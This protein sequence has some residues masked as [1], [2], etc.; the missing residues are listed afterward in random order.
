MTELRGVF[1]AR[2]RAVAEDRIR[3]VREALGSGDVDEARREM[4][5]L[6]GEARVVGFDVVARIAHHLEE[7]LEGEVAGELLERGLVL[8]EDALRLDPDAEP[9]GLDS[10]LA[11]GR[12][13]DATATSAAAAEPLATIRDRASD[14][15]VRADLGVLAGLVRSTAELRATERE[16]GT[17]IEELRGLEDDE[18]SRE[19]LLA[20]IRRALGGARQLAFDHRRRCDA[21]ID[22]IRELRMVPLH[23]LFE[24]FPRAIAQLAA[25]L[26][27]EV[28]VEVV[29]ADVEIDRQV[30]EVVT[31]PLLHLVRNA[32]DHGLETPDERR[33]GGKSPRGKIALR[34]RASGGVAR[35]EVEDDGRGVDV[36]AV[37][38]AAGVSE[39][40][41]EGLLDALCRHGLSTRRQVTDVS[42]RGVGLDV[43][44]RR[45]ASVG[46]RLGLR[47]TPGEGTRFVLELPTSMVLSAMVCVEVDGARYALAPH[48][49]GQVL[50]GEA[51]EPGPA[52]RGRAVRI[53]ERTLPLVDLGV[54][55]G[56]VSSPRDRER[57]LVLHQGER[58][59]AAGIDRFMGTRPVSEQ[60]L[61]PFLEQLPIVR[62]V[63]VLANGQLAVVLDVAD[64]IR[65]AET[66]DRSLVEKPTAGTTDSQGRVLVVDDSELTRDIVVAALREMGL[67]VVEAADGE[68]AL[69][70]L[71]RSVVSLVITDLDM[72]VLDGFELLRRIR[73]SPHHARI[74]VVVLSTRGSESDLAH[75][76]GLGADAYLIKGR[77]ELE[78]LRGV[79]RRYVGE[80][81]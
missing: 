11:L 20:G 44:K 27:K 39:L 78:Q 34:V 73:A 65:R 43:V 76:S 28:D 18:L 60:R 10:F 26:E 19:R 15:F 57:V 22:G 40:D 31:E 45:L 29:G 4:H 58:S 75:A 61:D 7:L 32:V 51:L 48:E 53:G 6:K 13:G 21:V 72:P 59:I 37:R 30:L 5:G 52:G 41:A 79:V 35:I 17:V 74:P 55:T 1:A 62:S 33:A 36:E 66:P 47:T 54:V 49:V 2:F 9:P 80:S 56:R 63:A 68:A 25:Q 8:I 70:E 81:A 24:P 64:V 12:E 42:G 23:E 67:E 77:L 3:L 69:A 38:A 71:D 14:A 46:G 50:D 16:L